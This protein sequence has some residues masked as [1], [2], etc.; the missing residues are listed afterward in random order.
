[1]MKRVLG[2]LVAGAV[3]LGGMALAQGA[4]Q[5]PP[6][7]EEIAAMESAFSQVSLFFAE[8]I[9]EVK[10]AVASLN[11][12]DVDLAARHRAL[13]T[14]LEGLAGRVE[15]A[16]DQIT[17]L[18]ASTE[19]LTQVDAELAAGIQSLA[20]DI[21]KTR[22]ELATAIAAL[23]DKVSDLAKQGTVHGNRLTALEGAVLSLRASIETCEAN[24]WAEIEA[25][26]GALQASLKALDGKFTEQIAALQGSVASLTREMSDHAG[27]IAALE[28]QDLGSVQRRVL[29]L[30]QAV[31]ALNI[32]IE[33]NREKIGYLE[34]AMGGFTSDVRTTVGALQAS[35]EDHEVRLT[36]VE[37]STAALQGELQALKDGLAMAQ[38]L[39]IV[40]LLA[41]LAALVLGL[42]G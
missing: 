21:E 11:A 6:A 20:T 40:G 34:K 38:G 5:L 14:R 31:Q 15:Q 39:A 23:A 25:R 16:W 26:E 3:L 41:G 30:E 35:V 7:E 42:L 12:V 22:Q 37:T 10:D 4:V 19:R 2:G 17:A 29:A 33:N 32:K 8:F 27:R 1:M 18:R 36:T 28:A 9:T 13:S 24:L